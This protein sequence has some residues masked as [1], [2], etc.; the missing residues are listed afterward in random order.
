MT[1]WISCYFFPFMMWIKFCEIIA[2]NFEDLK[3][4][5]SK[6]LNLFLFVTK[7]AQK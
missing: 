4:S 7:S 2:G 1:Q 6:D 5:V 3:S